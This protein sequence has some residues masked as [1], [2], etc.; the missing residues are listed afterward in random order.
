MG[1]VSEIHKHQ[2]KDGGGDFR[3]KMHGKLAALRTLGEHYGLWRGEAGKPRATNYMVFLEMVKSGAIDEAL[4]SMGFDPRKPIKP[5]LDARGMT[6]ETEALP[7][8]PS[9]SALSDE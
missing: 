6:A 4:R 1:A 7:A 3:L 9:R 2:D 8:P 5:Q